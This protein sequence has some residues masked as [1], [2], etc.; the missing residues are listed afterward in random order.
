MGV[1]FRNP[2]LNAGEIAERHFFAMHL[3]GWRGGIGGRLTVTDA[4][5]IFMANRFEPIFGGKDWSVPLKDVTACDVTGRKL[6]L[7]AGG[8][9]RR[10]LV[11]LNDGSQE[12]FV[13]E[14]VDG[15]AAVLSSRLARKY[16][17]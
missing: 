6:N 8:W 15:I 4:R 1:W 12:Q 17:I 16:G 11:T 7:W 2:L 3:Q 14:D 13:V 9:R 10:L 5:L